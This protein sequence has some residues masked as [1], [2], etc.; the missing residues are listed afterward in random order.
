MPGEKPQHLVLLAKYWQPGQVKTRLAKAIGDRSAAALHRAFLQT[1][2]TRLELVADRR[3]VAFTPA[4]FKTEFAEV[5]APSWQL[6]PQ[7][8]GHLGERLA[9]CF[10]ASFAA[11]ARRVVAIGSDSPSLPR[12]LVEEAFRRLQDQPVVLGPSS[13]G[14]YYLVGACDATPPIFGQLAWGTARVWNQTVERL[15]AAEIP[16]AALS[17]W[18]DVDEQADLCR[19]RDELNDDA[20]N[21]DRSLSCLRQRIDEILAGD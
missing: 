1:L 7:V 14:G 13:D 8:E 19:L 6:M 3:T 4:E 18:Y 12:T 20:A 10:D 15:Q 9:A 2:L 11:G 5:A 21:Q 16:F 17:R